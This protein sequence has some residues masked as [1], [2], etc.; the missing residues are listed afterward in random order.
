MLDGPHQAQVAADE[1][2]EEVD[3]EQEATARVG[4]VRRRV[5]AALVQQLHRR[6]KGA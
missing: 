2:A 1:R 3:F 4:R 6:R 5:D